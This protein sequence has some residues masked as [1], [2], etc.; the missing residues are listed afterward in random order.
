MFAPERT[1]QAPLT[2]DDAVA[3]LRSRWRWV[4][5]I[6]LLTVAAAVG[7]SFVR[8]PVYVSE[9]QVLVKPVSGAGRAAEAQAPNMTTERQLAR[10]IP[11]ATLA[12]RALDVRTAPEDLLVDLSV[13]VIEDTEILRLTYAHAEPDDARARAQAFADAYLQFRR[14]Q[15]LA[16][17]D[18]TAGDLKRQ[19]AALEAQLADVIRQIDRTQDDA[20]RVS[21]EAQRT[22]L[23]GQIGV[24]RTDLAA[25]EATRGLDVGQTVKPADLPEDPAS[26][27]P[28]RDAAIALFVGLALGVATAFVVDRFDER[29]READGLEAVTGTPVLAVIPR[30]PADL[31]ADGP[32]LTIRHPDSPYAEAY[33][34]LRSGFLFAAAGRN[35]RAVAVTSALPGDGKTITTA[36]LGVA[37]AQSGK[38]VVLVSADLR[39]PDLGRLFG[40]ENGPG[41]TDVLERRASLWELLVRAER[42][43]NLWLLPAGSAAG[44]P[45][46]L[47]S[48]RAMADLLSQLRE[49]TDIALIDTGPVLSVPDA[50][51]LGPLVD[52]MIVVAGER[53]TRSAVRQARRQLEIVKAPLIG[54]V[55]NAFRA[56]SEPASYH[57]YGLRHQPRQGS[58]R[59]AR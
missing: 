38:R 27:A 22:G 37:I 47:L 14:E 24:L 29:F 5:G 6:A 30:I 12:A 36:N 33:R 49:S 35:A 7:L 17:S 43:D 39:K 2:L 11:V 18:V 44:V 55:L 32:L 57:E 40:I 10:S 4:A 28:V 59:R 45:A 16:A 48:S 31:L 53:A 34:T 3:V 15:A 46:D 56:Q 26:P 42:V 9:A 50:V 19:I 52:G 41:L 8:T 23:A 21:L 25:I 54:A 58:A 51:A 1:E 20:E 13:D